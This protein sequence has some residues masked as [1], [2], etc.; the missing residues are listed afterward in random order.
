MKKSSCMLLIGCLGF[1]GLAQAEPMIEIL[2]A[3]LIGTGCPDGSF[4]INSTPSGDEI[5]ILFQNYTA[6]TGSSESFDYADCNIA[7]T[8]EFEEGLTIG[9]IG[10]DYRGFS[11]MAE[12]STGTFYRQYFFAGEIGN[13]SMVTYDSG[14]NG[15]FFE[16]DDI[17]AGVWSPCG[18]TDTIARANTS[19][20]VEGSD[21][22]LKLAT[23]DTSTEIVFFFDW[24]WC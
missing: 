21:S 5:S 24:S 20:W 19:I 14:D 11:R 6:Q 2:E 16:E 12:G 4:L 23:M 17:L 10:I 18:E 13:D 7:L 15:M 22:M 8:L 1:S 9:L 3:N